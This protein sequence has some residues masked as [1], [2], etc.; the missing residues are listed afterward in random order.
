[1][2]SAPLE[3]PVFAGRYRA[4]RLLKQ[5]LGVSTYLGV[6]VSTRR[7]VVI[8]TAPVNALASAVESRLE[9]EADVLGRLQSPWL[10]SLLS[11][12]REGNA[13]TLVLPYVPGITLAERLSAGPLA[14]LEAARVGFCVA[15]ALA[16]AHEH[17][18]LHRDVKPANVIVEAQRS[19][20]HATLIDFGLARSGRL[21]PTLRELPVGTVRYTSPEQAGLLHREVDERSDLYSTGA[22]LFECLAGEP[23]FAGES[24]GEVLRQ[25]LT[26][27][28]P[29]L[30]APGREVPRALEEIVLRLLRKDP[31]D[32]YQSA[33]AAAADLRA[34][35]EALERGDADPV[36]AIGRLDRRITLT[37]P[38][39]LGRARELARLESAIQE[40]RAG[41]GGLVL[42]E[43]ESG[44]GKTRL[45]DE[46]A[47]HWARQGVSVLRGQGVDQVAQSPY[48]LLEGV[49]RG[50]LYRA[51]SEAGF[52]A[53][54]KQRLAGQGEALL[55]ALPQLAELVGPAPEVS[56]GPELHG[57]LRSL[58]ALSAFLGS[59][60]E[61]ERP[62]LV[63][64]D[65]CQW[66]DELTLK[67][68]RHFQ[69]RLEESGPRHVLLVVAFRS[70]D[71]GGGHALREVR[72]LAHVTLPPFGAEDVQR[73]VESMAGAVPPEVQD[74]VTRLAE[75]SPFMASA[76]LRGLVESGA[77]VS[78][79]AGWRVDA[80]A[81]ADVS[82][83]RR[84]AVFLTR[85][86]ELLPE[87]ALRLLTLGAVL[88]KKFDLPLCAAL[89]RQEPS[90]AAEAIAEARR[91]HLVWLE[92]DTTAAFV[93][94]KLRETLLAR[95]DDD[96]RRRFH[97]LAAER[98]EER[99][100][101][102]AFDLAYHFDAA[103]LD[104]R[105][106]PY[107]LEAAAQARDR[108]ALEVAERQLEI[109]ER[110]TREADAA[111]RLPVIEALGD[112]LMLRGRYDEAKARLESALRLAESDLARVPIETKLGELAFKRGDIKTASEV[113]ERAL[114]LLGRSVP[115]GTAGFLARAAGE[116]VVQAAHTLAPRLFLARRNAAGAE[117]E[118][119]AIHLY[120]RLAY[121]YWFQRGRVPC[122]WAHFREMNLAERY[123]PTLEL[124]QAYSEH[125]PVMTML[126][127]FRR[128]VA[129]A[130]RSLAIRR[131]LGDVWGQGQSLH[132]Y[133][134]VLYASSRYRECIDRCR[135]AVRLLERTGDQW[136]VHVAR[137][138]VAFSLHRLGDL[139]GA[140]DAARHVYRSALEIG[141]LQGA[142][143]ALGVWSKASG[144]RIPK[145]LVEAARRHQTGDVHAAAEIAM[146]D[147]CRLL[148]DGSPDRAVAVLRESQA[149]IEAKGLRQEYVAPV[150]PWLATALRRQVEETHAW[151]PRERR[152]LLRE[153]RVA[154]RR[155]LRIA[156]TY[157]NNLPHA[158]RE[159]GLIAALDGRER[160]ARER[161]AESLR[162]AEEQGALWERAQTRLALA[163]L[164][165]ACG[166]WRRRGDRLR[167]VS[168][169]F[170]VYG[171]WR[172]RGDRL[173]QVS[174]DPSDEVRAAAMDV[175]LLEEVPVDQPAEREP[176]TLSLADRF[177]SIL[178]AGRRIATA[179][180]RDAVCTALREGALALLRGESCR[181]L[182]AY[183]EGEARAFG[184]DPGQPFSRT[185][186]ERAVL[187]SRPVS[188]TEDTGGWAGGGSADESM[189]LTH[190]RSALCAPVLVRG[191]AEV[192][193]Y[194]THAQVGG[195]FAAEEERLAEFLATLA[196]AALENAEGF[197][198]VQRLSSSLERRV[199]ERTAELSS[200]NTSLGSALSLLQA[201][202]E[203][204]ADGILVVDGNG[205]ITGSNRK[206][207]EMWGVPEEVMALRDDQRAIASVLGK[208]KDPEHFL[209][210]VRELYSSPEAESFD[211]LELTDGRV[212]ERFSKPQGV[213]T[214]Y[215]GRVWSFR[216][217]TEQRRAETAL[218]ASVREK[219]VL[220]R[221]VHHRVK[222]NLQVISSLLSLQSRALHGDMD[223][224]PF[225]ES[226]N[227]V[228]SM[229]L[230]HESLYKSQ[231]LARI[232]L[233]RY[234]QDL[235]RILTDSYAPRAGDI[236]LIVEA[237]DVTITMDAAVS[238]GLIVH[239]LVANAL[240]YAYPAGRT[241]EVRVSLRS[242]PDG[243][244]TLGVSDDGVGLPQE[245]EPG[246][247]ATLGLKLAGALSEQLGGALEIEPGR[248]TT[249]KVRF[250]P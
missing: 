191:R 233:K 39:F 136:E 67:L 151:A 99:A 13:L 71:V 122:A 232:D 41:R 176:V 34:V 234:L 208:L 68:L 1:M 153:A 188:A 31:R 241:G 9:H 75:G 97:R 102:R 166:A 90:D 130:E 242:A 247:P 116:A 84:A 194:L 126:P 131:D 231:D 113:L 217:V 229:A 135:E 11:L 154:A 89:A 86:L 103:G 121:A 237:D 171:A 3:F 215:V 163:Q 60:G 19:L 117:A 12:T 62:A 83:S 50:S 159:A 143:L 2:S 183:G 78:E 128:G 47:E 20:E 201:T 144:G 79:R 30:R 25:H 170:S 204:T 146:A 127:Y 160:A 10:S 115:R 73:L 120:S 15:S 48:Q 6:E 219:D 65:D 218:R 95:L 216:D 94:D 223:R 147:A 88:G 209:T 198:E 205:M 244:L 23:P 43:A 224:A 212:F 250:K 169:W 52:A 230:I 91:R 81:M 239:E 38:A 134:V 109:A 222:N 190:V 46:L 186:V 210:K 129:Y 158:L 168:G 200:A 56:L 5:G 175:E 156:F 157:R 37:E 14:P 106:L 119:L 107:A 123:P 92:S 148:R 248:L 138:H 125:A 80:P 57:E 199:V 104:E 51:R 155:A 184:D 64:L 27:P 17:G 28:P 182:E 55:S 249:F 235:G 139:K 21:D 180:T 137:L 132:F 74:T 202:L 32:R 118:L 207:A 54:L 70:E 161:L 108:H 16:A 173:R 124:A 145:E 76:V 35:A 44:G 77:L 58:R 226:E 196:G 189:V 112:V 93:H 33:E 192:C 206:F 96:E 172:R 240:K 167:Q 45:L 238:C 42:L 36:V 195:L 164:N 178:D 40:A 114:R 193:L 211:I 4:L 181:I 185:L 98:L 197:R 179:L 236:R 69:R 214:E 221:E 110:G 220:L 133:G 152:A 49:V 85:R 59:L 8:K 87:S 140:V 105:A 26:Q 7:D 225:L 177:A 63:L 187:A 61:A 243:K 213:G 141:D 203:S 228:R 142:A 53:H 111:T 246:K 82:S 150:L 162:V 18:V 149:Q 100:P 227:R 174:G 72:P 22:V 245:F 24:V 66:A 101:E 29:E 165:L